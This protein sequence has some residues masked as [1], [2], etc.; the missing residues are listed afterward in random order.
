M[1][2]IIHGS[3]VRLLMQ[4]K[5]LYIL[6]KTMVNL[7]RWPNNSLLQTFSYSTVEMQRHDIHHIHDKDSSCV[8]SG[9]SREQT[10]LI[11]SNSL[12]DL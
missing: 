8:L 5:Q 12:G 2:S 7:V 11:L 3:I 4:N 1:L 6:S 10:G 9:L